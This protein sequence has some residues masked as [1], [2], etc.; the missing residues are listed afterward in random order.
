MS[1]IEIRQLTVHTRL[2][3][4]RMDEPFEGNP[5]ERERDAVH[6]LLWTMTGNEAL[7][8]NHL[9]SGKPIL[10]GWHIS[11]SHSRGFAAV[12]L[13]ENQEVAV[14]IEYQSDRVER[15][16][17]K[18]IREDELTENIEEM[19]LLWSAKE[20][21]YKLHS[22]DHLQYFDMRLCSMKKGKSTDDNHNLAEGMM[23][24][25]NM[26]KKIV[27]DICFETTP[28]YVLTYAF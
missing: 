22:D 18:F 25:E 4:W 7:R 27:V 2:G 16:A 6:R 1:L 3:L 24:I 26:K 15:I 11:I 10:D 17:K 19:L 13:S 12:I 20:T 14:D 8:I 23:Q 9:A 21:L 5:R 28:D